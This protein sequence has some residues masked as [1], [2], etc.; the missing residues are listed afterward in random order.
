MNSDPTPGDPDRVRELA[1]KLQAFADDASDAL[2]KVRDLVGDES[3]AS[4]VGQTAEAFKDRFDKVPPNLTKL[5]TS[6]DLAA[7]ALARYWPKLEDAQRDA[8]SALTDA[9]EAKSDLD[10]AQSLL[11][12]A[13]TSLEDAENA[14]EDP[15]EDAVAAEVRRALTDAEST[16]SG[17]ESTV[18]SAR[19]RLETAKGL[20]QQAKEAREEAAEACA[21]DL[22]EASDAGMQNKKWWQKAVDWVVDNWDTIVDIAKIVVAVLGVIVMIIGGPLAWVVLA[23]ALIVLADTLIDYANGNASLWDVA[24]AALDCIPGM[25]GITSAAGLMKGLKTG[26]KGMAQGAKGL[27]KNLK[28][29]AAQMFKRN[30]CGDPVDVATGQ[31]VLSLIDVE[32]PG[33]LPL[34]LERHHI[35]TYRIGRSFGRSWASTLDQRLI[36][37]D[38]GAQFVADD[39]MILVYPIPLADP[40]HPVLPVEGPRWGLGWNG[41]P[42]GEMTIHQRDAGRTLHF[43]PIPGRKGGELPLTAITDRNNNRIDFHYADDGQLTSVTHSGGYRIGVARYD[44]RVS[45]LTLLSDPD[46]PVLVSY[47]YDDAGNLD[48]IYNS[49]GEP[50]RFAYDDKHRIVRWEDRNNTWYTYE[51]DESGRCVFTTGTDRALEYRYD[52]DEAGRR[53]IATNGL[54]HATVYQFNDRYQLVAETDPIGRTITREWDRRDNLLSETDPLGHTSRY[55]YDE[56]GDPIAVVRPDGSRTEAENGE[57]GQPI[58]VTQPDGHVWRMEYDARGN[59]TGD[60]DPT[61]AGVSYHYNDI[62]ST[63]AITDAAGRTAQIQTDAAGM[64]IAST[65][66]EGVIT[67]YERDAFG[68]LAAVITPDGART[69]LGWTTEGQLSWRTLPDG[70]TEHRSYDGEGNLV[71]HTDNAGQVTRFEYGAFDLPSVR[72]DPDGTRLEFSYDSELRMTS[73]TNQL[74]ATWTYTYDGAGQLIREQDFNGRTLTYRHDAAERL[75]ERTNGSGQ[76]TVYIRNDLGNVIEE[77]SSE[78]T[79]TF[80]YDTLGFLRQARN[81]HAE[82]TYER[83]ARG[84]ILAETCNGATV[85]SAYDILGR[86]TRRV[87]PSGAESSWEYDGRDQAVLLRTAGRTVTFAYDSS[88]RETE[89]R[90]GNALLTQEWDPHSRLS[91]QTLTAADLTGTRQPRRLQQRS[92]RYRP[93]GSVAA[94]HDLIR[95]N[96]TFDLD[97]TGR[98][99][100]VHAADW[101]E[102]YAYD[103]AGN[104]SQGRWQKASATATAEPW[105]VH[106]TRDVHYEYDDHG[107]VVLRRK[108][109]LSRKADVWRYTWDSQDRLIGATTPDGARWL[110]KYDPFGRRITK[111]KLGPDGTTVIEE[112][113]FHWDDLV[114]AEQITS[115]SDGASR[116]TT[117]DWERDRFSP[118]TQIERI[119]ARD[120]AQEWVDEQFYSIVTDVI[121]APAELVNEQAEIA[122]HMRGTV[123]GAPL[124]SPN[125]DSASCPLRFPGQYHDPETALNY[126][127]YRHYDPETGQYTSLD[128]LG[129]A[130]GPNPQSYVTNPFTA[131]DPLGLATPCERAAQAARNRADLE[132]ARPGANKH[133]RPTSASGL[134][135]P[136]S[137]KTYDGASMKGGSNHDLHPDVQAA[138]DRVPVGERAPGNQ[139]GNCGEAE[140]LSNALRDGTNPRGGTMAA[141]NVRAE[142]NPAHGTP[143]APCQSCAEVLKDF[144]ITVVA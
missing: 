136:G 133:T 16:H 57:Y 50:F 21:N 73:V 59:L 25:K 86:R 65:D 105:P 93:D 13:A 98:V 39:G 123:W 15:D 129:L 107:R 119:P 67:R 23:A 27:G 51:Y 52:Y 20:A 24:F 132:Q 100:A 80:A 88:G 106:G 64:P 141:V 35:S 122:W 43:N 10:S 14:A 71:E 37:D 62:G 114:L 12:A 74:G 70:T 42:G 102:Q 48:Q 36:L 5:H 117:W 40:E 94:I 46:Q 97:L 30:T 56:Y 116:C 31:V 78:D 91:S 125:T 63:A 140:A 120:Q 68:R 44:D 101:S 96:R 2:T 90:A 17:A 79:T 29:T 131:I 28:G 49:S 118:I 81:R 108:K 84:R 61:G 66:A 38:A 139:H 113:C 110:Y 58:S 77:R 99:T 26:M 32:L 54:G 60:T 3:L 115:T 87:T 69:R 92:Y 55:E 89:R 143:K 142:G 7:Q 22:D 1:E 75:I 6:Y 33:V 137:N 124:N 34:T 104:L 126:N 121:G 95:G 144:D 45:S 103:D 18:A 8:D 47:G 111:Q 130:P 109:R 41:R 128:P 83:D 11:S 112:V 127:Y 82:L 76:T 4:F 53:T 135:V 72:I 9:T 85:C 134:S 138:Y 19:E